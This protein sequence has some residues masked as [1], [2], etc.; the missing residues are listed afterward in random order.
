MF[1]I[2]N[3][4]TAALYICRNRVKYI[5]TFLVRDVFA[6]MAPNFCGPSP[7]HSK[8]VNSGYIFQPAKTFFS[9][10]LNNTC[11]SHGSDYED[12]S[13]LG[14]KTVGPNPLGMTV[15]LP[16]LYLFFLPR[17]CTLFSHMAYSYT[18]KIET[19]GSSGTFITRYQTTW[20]H[21]PQD[22][23]FIFHMNYQHK[24]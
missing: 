14:H 12:Y 13:V 5:N 6:F 15:Q 16:A 24:G 10:I 20:C 17:T 1:T 18:L 21:I 11:T 3:H 2:I 19:V 7:I 9:L 23:S 22:F 4:H 8:C